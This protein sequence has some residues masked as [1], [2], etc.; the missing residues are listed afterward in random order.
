MR[1]SNKI[2]LGIFFLPLLVL[3]TVNTA[4]YTKYKTGHYIAMAVVEQE[5][6][7][8]QDLKNIHYVAVYGLNNFTIKPADTARLQIEKDEKGHLH[9]NI[10]GDSLVIHGDSLRRTSKEDEVLR[11]YQAVTLYLPGEANIFADNTDLYLEGATD[12]S[13][14][15]SIQ[16]LLNNSSRF[17]MPD[18]F[19]NEK[20]QY[21]NVL[22]VHA[23]NAN[24][25]EL[26]ATARISALQLV[27]TNTPFDDK[28]A[29]IGKLSINADKTSSLRLKGDNLEKIKTSSHE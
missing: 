17:E 25:I 26:S 8:R 7:T 20:S 5:R 29:A 3:A 18:D 21:F 27:L 14:S 1:T 28:S 22:S 16:L 4:L 23:N 24:G 2:L 19:D 9:Y 13:K 11:S 15:K 6:Y 12:S 10:Q